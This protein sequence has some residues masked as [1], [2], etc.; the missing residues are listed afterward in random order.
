MEKFNQKTSVLIYR[1]IGKTP[2]EAIDSTESDELG[3]HYE[4][5]LT[6]LIDIAY[7][8]L[9]A[10]LVINLCRSYDQL[11]K[12]IIKRENK[13]Y[14]SDEYGKLLARLRTRA[15]RGRGKVVKNIEKIYVAEI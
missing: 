12:F 6:D 10:Y 7:K 11:A 9:E 4:R 14:S 8:E 1:A 13:E 15:H 5:V 2:G 3:S